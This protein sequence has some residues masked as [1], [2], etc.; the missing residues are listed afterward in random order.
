MNQVEGKADGPSAERRASLQ[1]ALNIPGAIRLVLSRVTRR[2]AAWLEPRDPA[3]LMERL[4]RGEIVWQAFRDAGAALIRANRF[5]EADRM[6][7]RGLAAFPGDGPLLVEY[8]LS[9]HNSGA[10]VL[11]I[12][13]WEEALRAAPKV[14]LCHAGLAA[15][16]RET[17]QYGRAS[18]VIKD[19]LRLFPEDTAV[20]TEAARIAVLRGDFPAALELWRK[21]CAT[22]DPHPDWLT[23]QVQALILLGYYE[24]AEAVLETAL[25]KHPVDSG[26]VSARGSLNAARQT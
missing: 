15:N 16:L 23:G 12:R 25:D 4:Q 2:I 9:A 6:I 20:L 14:A 17:L 1:S 26:L 13:R 18:T 11:A 5:I 7:E 21:A 19:A 24:D 3:R 10:Y 8:A 22:P